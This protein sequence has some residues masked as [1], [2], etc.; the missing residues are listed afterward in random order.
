M[1]FR[2]E[3]GSRTP[4]PDP[5]IDDLIEANARDGGIERRPIEDLEIRK[6]CLYPLINEAANI[7]ADGIA[8]RPGDIDVVWVYGYGFPAFRGGPLRYAD[9]L[10]L[11]DIYDDMLA[12]EKIHGANWTPSPLLA[13]LATSGGTFGSGTGERAWATAQ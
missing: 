6:R 10:G 9:T 11:R 13:H 5:I 1:L 4:I 8:A 3:P 7:L 2:S 12:L